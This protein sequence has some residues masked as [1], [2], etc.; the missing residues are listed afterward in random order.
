MIRYSS[1]VAEMPKKKQNEL[2]ANSLA[3]LY[4]SP[5]KLQDQEHR[6]CSVSMKIQSICIFRNSI[7]SKSLSRI[8]FRSLESNIS[9]FLQRWL[10]QS[11]RDNHFDRMPVFIKENLIFKSSIY[12]G[13]Q[14]I[15]YSPKMT[16]LTKPLVR[17]FDG[18]AKSWPAPMSRIQKMS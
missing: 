17:A 15:D 14:P 9:W 4:C 3:Q 5:L 1:T 6:W 18:M 8:M 11:S 13:N 7:I 2:L 10:S 12:I 16:G